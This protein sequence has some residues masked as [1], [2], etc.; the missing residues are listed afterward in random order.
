MPV[1]FIGLSLSREEAGTLLTAEIRPPVRRGDLDQLSDG[2]VVAIIDGDLGDDLVL[3]VI[4]IRR[5]LRRGL[6]I[7][8]AASVGALLAHEARE[9]GMV[10]HGWVYEA[11]RSGR[12]AGTD[13]IKVMYEP[14]S[15]RPLTIPLIN[16]RFCL[17]YLVN[18]GSISAEETNH[19]MASLKRWRLERRS[20]RAI[21]LHLA[22]LFGEKRARSLLRLIMPA[23]TDVKR[24]DAYELLRSLMTSSDC[25]FHN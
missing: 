10:G 19:A 17:E 8:G 13:E 22:Q 2:T 6:K 3:P 11:Y 7:S 21:I 18:R 4:E 20:R 24:N 1:V 16:V 9:E 25:H 23:K 12:I 15:Y 14:V 5:G